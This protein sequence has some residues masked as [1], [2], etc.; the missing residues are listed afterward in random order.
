MEAM[1]ETLKRLNKN[2][3][4]K[5]VP[6]VEGGDTDPELYFYSSLA[7]KNGNMDNDFFGAIQRDGEIW[8]VDAWNAIEWSET[9]PQAAIGGKIFSGAEGAV[10]PALFNILG[11]GGMDS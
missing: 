3:D 11:D 4:R 5:F 6:E 8:N 7:Q 2:K 1:K 10:D 9:L